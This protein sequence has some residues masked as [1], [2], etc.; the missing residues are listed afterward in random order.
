MGLLIYASL[1]LLLTLAILRK[2]S[3]FVLLVL[4]LL[5]FLFLFA[6]LWI[7][8]ANY[9][10]LQVKKVGYQFEKVTKDYREPSRGI[11]M[12]G[13]QQKDDLFVPSLPPGAIKL[14]P[15]LASSTIDVS[16][17]TNGV[18]LMRN[19]EWVNAIT[20]KDD[21]RIQCGGQELTF[22]S[23]GAFHRVFSFQQKEWIWPRRKW[24][25]KKVSESILAGPNGSSTHLLSE[26]ANLK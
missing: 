14:T 24:R 13:D 8:R 18:L 10:V 20:L 4:Q 11:F 19:E 12:G 17:Q 23:K 15:S 1:A 22:H 25:I 21:D 16:L 26:I 5:P 7:S 3:R 6:F 9:Q 2:Y